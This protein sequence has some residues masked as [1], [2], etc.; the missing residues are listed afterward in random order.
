MVQDRDEQKDYSDK[1]RINR[2]NK[3]DVEVE[4]E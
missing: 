1:K 2:Y 4:G 3:L